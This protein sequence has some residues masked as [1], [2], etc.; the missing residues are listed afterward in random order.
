VLGVIADRVSLRGGSVLASES[1][2][3]HFRLG[4][5]KIDWSFSIPD[6]RMSPFETVDTMR[7][8]ATSLLF[9]LASKAR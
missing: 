5:S 8:S 9:D 1:K 3:T 6:A 7:H 4:R 2:I